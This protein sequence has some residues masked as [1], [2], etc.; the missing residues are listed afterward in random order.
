MSKVKGRTDDMLIIRGVNV[1]PSQVEEV[2]LDIEGTEPHYLIVLDRKEAMDDFEVRVEITE[3][4]F[5]DEMKVV[6][7]KALEIERRLASALGVRPRVVL[8][9]PRSLERTTG[10]AKRVLDRRQTEE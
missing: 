9:E 3:S 5:S 1:F 10:K 6:R 7:E 2:L 4:L 8:V